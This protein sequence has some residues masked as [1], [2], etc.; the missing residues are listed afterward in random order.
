M[1]DRAR[2]LRVYRGLLWLYPAEFRDHF[3]GEMCRALA[4]CLG[5]R[6]DPFEVLRLYFG[7]LIDGTDS[8]VQG[9]TFRHQRRPFFRPAGRPCG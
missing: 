4:D 1:R 6:P 7:V 2:E 8:H 5:A 3:A 9:A